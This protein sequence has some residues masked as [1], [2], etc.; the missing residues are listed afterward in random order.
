[1]PFYNKFTE[2]DLSLT[3]W[4]A[5]ERTVLANERNLLSYIRTLLS[6][7]ISGAGIIKFFPSMIVL[8]SILIGIGFSIFVFGFR[9]YVRTREKLSSFKV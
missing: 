3:D 6:F 9:H 2:K 5:V 4:L 8:G 7:S 1:M